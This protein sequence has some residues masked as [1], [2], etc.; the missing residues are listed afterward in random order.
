MSEKW[1]SYIEGPRWAFGPSLI[2]D[3]ARLS[4]TTVVSVNES[5]GFIRRTVFFTLEGTLEDLEYAQGLLIEAK[6]AYQGS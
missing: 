3:L 1:T 5:K 2:Y 6:R 4:D